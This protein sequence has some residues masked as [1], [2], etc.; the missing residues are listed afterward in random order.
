VELPEDSDDDLGNIV[1]DGPELEI[2]VLPKLPCQV[3]NFVNNNKSDKRQSQMPS[4]KCKTS[5]IKCLG[6][7][8]MT[9]H[10]S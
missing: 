8:S 6:T 4:L 1:K 10:K 2:K 3:I 9:G 5:W 7:C